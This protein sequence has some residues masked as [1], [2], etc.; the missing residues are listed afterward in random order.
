MH[1]FAFVFVS[2]L[3]SCVAIA[4]LLTH[5]QTFFVAKINTPKETS[6]KYRHC[7]QK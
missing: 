4:S 2:A 1:D 6:N 5:S 3:R 7:K